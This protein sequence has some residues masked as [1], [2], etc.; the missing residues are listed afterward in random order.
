MTWVLHHKLQSQRHSTWCQK[1]RE[2]DWKLHVSLTSFILR[3]L[4]NY[5]TQTTIRCARS[6]CTMESTW[7]TSYRNETAGEDFI[8][9]LTAQRH[10]LL[11]KLAKAKFYSPLLNGSNDREHWSC[12]SCV[13][14][15]RGWWE[16]TYRNGWWLAD[17][18]QLQL[19]AFCMCWIVL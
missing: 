6:K 10:D 17:H 12:V 13:V 8:H 16:D 11:H 15:S 4:K 19:K 7:V 9:N 5:Y 2:Q 3:R 1:V 14:W 18:G